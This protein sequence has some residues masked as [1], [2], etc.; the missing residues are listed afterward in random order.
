MEKS[1]LKILEKFVNERLPEQEKDRVIIIVDKKSLTW[2]QMIEELKKD[3]DFSK[4]V[5]EAFEELLK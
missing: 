2:K 5:E 3:D 1:K 4:K